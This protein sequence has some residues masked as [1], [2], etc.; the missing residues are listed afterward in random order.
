MYHPALKYYNG[1]GI[2]YRKNGTDMDP[3]SFVE[4]RCLASNN[5]T[6]FM[7]DPDSSMNCDIGSSDGYFENHQHLESV[8]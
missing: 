8:F 1:P 2:M 4:T 3:S 7:R 6:N 5:I